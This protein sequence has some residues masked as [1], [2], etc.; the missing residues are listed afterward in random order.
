MIVPE[1]ETVKLFET[2]EWDALWRLV[3]IQPD[4]WIQTTLNMFDQML[5]CVPPRAYCSNGFLVGEPNDFR[6][7]KE[8]WY[9]FIKFNGM[10]LVKELTF[11]EFKTLDV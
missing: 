6:D 4:S 5:G 8:T 9:C 10:V 3:K 2:Y 7:G 1:I 11:S